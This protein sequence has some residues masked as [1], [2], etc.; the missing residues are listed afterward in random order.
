MNPIEQYFL[1]Q[2]E[3]YQSIMLYV[4]SVI[5]KTLPDVEERYS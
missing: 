1:S 2:K 5:F 3:P 4:R